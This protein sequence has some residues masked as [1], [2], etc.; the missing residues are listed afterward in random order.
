MRAPILP[1]TQWLTTQLLHIL[2]GQRYL[3]PEVPGAVKTWIRD[4]ISPPPPPQPH[5]PTGPAG[6]HTRGE[7]ASWAGRPRLP[8]AVAE[9]TAQACPSP[10]LVRPRTTEETTPQTSPPNIVEGAFYPQSFYALLLGPWG[11]PSN[12]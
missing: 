4:L 3:V 9:E 7:P 12:L 1:S 8:A 6:L 2:W 11:N 5:R 10:G